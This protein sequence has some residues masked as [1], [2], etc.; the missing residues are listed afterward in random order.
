M[1]NIPEQHK[2]YDLLPVIRDMDFDAFDYPARIRSE[3]EKL[4]PKGETLIPYGYAC[5]E[6]FVRHVED[7]EKHY[8]KTEAQAELFRN[9]I[10][11]TRRLNQKEYWSVL[12]YVG[13][14]WEEWDDF[15]RFTPGRAYYWPCDPENPEYRGIIDDVEFTNYLYAPDPEDWEILE[16]PTGMAYETMYGKDR[17]KWKWMY[18]ETDDESEGNE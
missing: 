11:D 15:L 16:D 10:E 18:E 3:S 1:A 12:R 4:L 5:I 14:E 17:D 2:K 6:A 7:L 8:A 9:Y 13:E